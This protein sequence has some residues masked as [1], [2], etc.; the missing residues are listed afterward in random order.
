MAGRERLI[1]SSEALGDGETG[2]RF[3]VR[4]VG[5]VLPAFAIRFRGVVRAYL[6]EC[7]HQATE[8][9]W[10]PGEFFDAERLYLV[11][12]THGA[13]YDPSSGVCVSGPCAGARLAA[14]AVRE[15]DGGVYCAEE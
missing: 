9:D 8:L 2:V 5:A 6:N 11:C 1:C 7:Q 3:E 12:A 15:H 4:R 10:N 13:C 14:V